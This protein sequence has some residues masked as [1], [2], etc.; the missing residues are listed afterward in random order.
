[1]RRLTL[2]AALENSTNGESADNLTVMMKG[3]LAETY[4]QALDLAYSKVDPA[5]GQPIGMLIAGEEN[6]NDTSTVG[7]PVTP[8][9]ASPCLEYQQQETQLLNDLR[10][11]LAPASGTGDGETF[12]TIYGVDKEDIKPENLIEITELAADPNVADK[13]IVV[14]DAT[15]PSADGRASKGTDKVVN[16]S[17][18]L[19]AITEAFNIKLYPS[20]IA[21]AKA[22][23][24]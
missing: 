5:T 20:L 3:P 17:K 19:E 1:M 10:D 9:P 15:Q 22:L 6:L 14:A 13:L 7:T 8:V 2:R 21:A 16:L 4:T 18:A 12:L 24:K 23:K 11:N